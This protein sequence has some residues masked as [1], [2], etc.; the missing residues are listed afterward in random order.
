MAPSQFNALNGEIDGQ[1][2]SYVFDVWAT[3]LQLR[4]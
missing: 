3:D 4:L 1:N 2:L